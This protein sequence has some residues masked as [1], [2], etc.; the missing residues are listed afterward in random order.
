M[1]SPGMDG[2]DRAS[3]EASWMCCELASQGQG[4]ADDPRLPNTAHRH[5]GGP[6]GPQAAGQTRD[7]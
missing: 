5:A 2:D 7:S 6:E 1:N 4:D 3:A